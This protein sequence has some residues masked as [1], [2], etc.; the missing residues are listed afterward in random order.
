MTEALNYCSAIWSKRYF[1]VSL[2]K[3]D[4]RR[5]YR[6]SWLGIGWSLMHPI[7]MTS[8]FCVVFSQLFGENIA[9]Y[10]PYVL[11][12][13]AFW[14]FVTGVA[15]EGCNCYYQGENYI[16]QSPAPLAIYPLR[17]TLGMAV[18]LAMAMIVLVV[19]TWCTRGAGNLWTIWALVPALAILFVFSWA[20][21]VCVGVANVMFPD[22]QHIVQ[23]GMQ[24]LFY[25]TPI[26]YPAKLLSDHGLAWVVACNPLAACLEMI[27]A[28][29]LDATL[30]GWQTYATALTATLLSVAVAA[31]ILSKAERRL[32]FYL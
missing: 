15:N 11:S 13:L 25:M 8:V 20:I 18:H 29:V 14:N 4:L 30:P 3:V 28:P 10:A 27:R 6:R 22:M 12:G 9:S 2:V 32:I 19:L 24:V 21:A 1:W 16:R 23:V 26:F 5:R 7:A 31:L 17:V